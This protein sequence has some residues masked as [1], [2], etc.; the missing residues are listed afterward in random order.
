MNKILNT[1]S[2]ITTTEVAWM[3]ILPILVSTPNLRRKLNKE[4]DLNKITEKKEEK[5][6]LK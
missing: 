2:N 1:Q 4:E 6:K 3:T 5:V